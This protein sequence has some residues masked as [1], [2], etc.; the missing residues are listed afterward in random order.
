MPAIATR[1]IKNPDQLR[2]IL[3]LRSEGW[4]HTAIYRAMNLSRAT[5]FR[6]LEEVE[7]LKSQEETDG[8]DD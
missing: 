5:Y 3:R 8:C 1:P 7:Q 2:L 4:T 6:R